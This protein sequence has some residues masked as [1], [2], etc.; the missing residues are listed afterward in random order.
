MPGPDR[1]AI[2]PRPAGED[3]GRPRARYPVTAARAA[4]RDRRRHRVLRVES[5]DVHHRPGAQRERW[6]HDGWLIT[7]AGTTEIMKIIGRAVTQLAPSV[8]VTAAVVAVVAPDP[9]QA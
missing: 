4:I 6:P 3:A 7:H 9:P 8:V 2:V 5:L 1:H